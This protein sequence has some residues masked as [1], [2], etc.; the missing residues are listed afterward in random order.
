MIRQNFLSLC[1]ILGLTISLA[2]T[3]PEKLTF[4]KY[5]QP[6]DVTLMLK[7]WSSRFPRLTKLIP[8]G[9]S[10][11]G[12]ELIIIRIAAQPKDSPEPDSRPAI[13]VSANLEGVHPIGT[14]AALMLIEKFLTKYGSDKKITHLLEK[15]TVYV[16]PL[17]NPDAAQNFFADIRY[18]RRSNGRPV[19]DDMDDLI[20]EDG[21]DDLNHD[22]YITQM[23]VKDPEGEWIPDP[24]EPRLMRKADPQKGEKGI[25]AIYTEGL[26]N[27]GDGKYNEDP[28]G[29][30]EL[31]RNFPHDFEYNVKRTGQWPISEKETIALVRFLVSHPNIAIVLNFSSENTF[32]NLQQTGKAKAARDKV[33]VP[34]QFATFLGL[35]PDKEYSIKEIVDILKG[36]N[37]APGVEITEDMVA[38]FFGLGP[39]VTIDKQ[40][41]PFMEAIQKEYKDA[42]KKAKLDY[43][44]KRAKGVGKGSFVAYCYYQL[45]VQVFSSDLWAIPEPKKESE[46]DTLTVD[47]L[48]SMSSEEFIALGEEKIDSFLKEQGAPPNFK[49]STLIKMVE[50]GRITPGKMAEMMEKMPKKPSAKGEEHPDSY[51]LKWSDS[52]LKGKGFVPWTPYKHPTLGNVEIGGFVPYL[53]TTPLPNEIEKTISFHTD[54]YI[55]LMDRLAELEIKKT[56]VESLGENL[57]NVT[58]YFTNSGWFPT[59]TAQGKRAQT[60]WPITVRLKTT[61]GQLIFSGRPIETIPYIGGSGDTKKLE[62]TIQG[63][64]GSK[65]T[66][67]ANSP[68]IGSVS[69][70][71]VLK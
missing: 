64:K 14:E 36:M 3:T 71:I 24:A 56:E 32:L 38:M 2:G 42:L 51:I 59:S 4:N 55:K 60:S 6:K 33:K 41:M 61:Q 17:L 57:Y 39:A 22:G 34:K 66:I 46:K 1:L 65:V 30:V 70:T 63:K 54:F 44:E 7:S 48:K 53:K 18:E 12:S 20:D 9:Q 16:A 50:S 21:P 49:A 35:E 5:H 62:W 23:R 19:D 67:T 40:D 8:I 45:G 68:K 47:K 11:E 43:P 37:I 29:G 25:Y 27:D 26:D 58:V 69:T 28:I 52:V 13:F 15:R 10:T 31:N